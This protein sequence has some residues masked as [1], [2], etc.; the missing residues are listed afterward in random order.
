MLI[1]LKDFNFFGLTFAM[2]KELFVSAETRAELLSAV[3]KS[4]QTMLVEVT[5]RLFS[6]ILEEYATIL[7]AV[8]RKSFVT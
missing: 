6:I 4:Y 5:E 2:D 1:D 8:V 7:V 3:C